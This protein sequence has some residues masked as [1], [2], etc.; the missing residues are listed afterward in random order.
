MIYDDLMADF[1]ARFDWNLLH[2]F[3]VVVQERSMTR[4][5]QKLHRTQPAISQAIRRLEDATG[6]SLLSRARDGLVPTAAGNILLEQ[7]RSV[8]ATVSRIPVALEGASGDVAGKIRIV[9]VDSVVSETL[10]RQLRAFFDRHPAVDLEIEVST[11]DSIIRSVE[12]GT[13]T[14]G[15]TGGIIPEHLDSRLLIRETY[16]LYCGAQHALVGQVQVNPSVLRRQPFIS[17]PA[18]ILGG[19]HMNEV[20]AFRA[21]MSIGQRVRGQSSIVNEVRRMIECGLGIGLLPV[22]LAAPHVAAGSLWQLPPYEECPQAPIYLVRNPAIELS[23]AEV[24]LLT[25]LTEGAEA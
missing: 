13:C 6:T 14:F 10:D 15:I 11:T 18:D 2:T 5:A 3:L 17:F 16:G 12:R 19:A 7:A 24:I 20:T 1:S 23:S 9:T 21:R 8:Y 25:S 22:H 4:A